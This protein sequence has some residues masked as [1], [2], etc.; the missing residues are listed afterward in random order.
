MMW[1]LQKIS[2]VSIPHGPTSGDCRDQSMALHCKVKK[3]MTALTELQLYKNNLSWVV[4][5]N[6]DQH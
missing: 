6:L 4:T 1:L 2:T 5:Q 3:W